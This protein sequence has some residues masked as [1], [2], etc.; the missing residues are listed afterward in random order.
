MSKL[1]KDFTFNKKKLSSLKTRYISVYLD[2]NSDIQFAFAREMLSGESNKYREEPNYF[3]DKWSDTLLLQLNIIKDPCKYFG[4]DR[5]ITKTELREITSWLTSPH[6]PLWLQF[7]N[8]E[9]STDDSVRYKGWFSDITP[10]SVGGNLMGLTLSF[11]C[12]SPFAYTEDI[13]N[14]FENAN[15]QS[16]LLKVSSD[17]LENYTYP[18]ISFDVKNNGQVYIC[19]MSDC[20]I[21]ENSI[22]SSSSFEELTRKISLYASAKKY[23]LRYATNSSGEVN[24]ICS[25]TA[26]EFYLKDAYGEEIKCAAYYLPDSKQYWIIRGGF[27]WVSLYRDLNITIDCQKLLIYDSIGRMVTYDKLGVSDVDSMYWLKLK[28][29]NNSI[30]IYGNGNNITFTHIEARKVGE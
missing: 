18:K 16:L 28:N 30:R 15:S 13:Q 2:G 12:T 22:L 6:K 20:E 19:N 25:D 27:M 17:S 14:K 3:G 24:K 29:G 21:L 1:F 10:F 4:N 9:S 23:E 8:M 26:V 11:K 7:E 5:I